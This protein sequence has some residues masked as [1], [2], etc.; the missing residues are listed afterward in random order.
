MQMIKIKKAIKAI[1]I[2]VTVIATISAIGL[3]VNGYFSKK[4]SDILLKDLKSF[5]DLNIVSIELFQTVD[6]P[7]PFV[8]E[9]KSAIEEWKDLFRNLKA[10]Y[11][12]EELYKDRKILGGKPVIVLKTET[13]KFSVYLY[14]DDYIEIDSSLYSVD[15]SIAKLFKETCCGDNMPITD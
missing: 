2:S 3:S 10:E 12:R 5:C 8:I 14:G 1:T 4:R 6:Y 15:D 7:E 13:D 9:N 11:K